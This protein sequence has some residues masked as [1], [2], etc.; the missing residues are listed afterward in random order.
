MEC[1]PDRRDT[2]DVVLDRQLLSLRLSSAKNEN[3][4]C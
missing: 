1:M 2:L 4:L 3:V